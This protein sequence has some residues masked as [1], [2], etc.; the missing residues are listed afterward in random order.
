LRDHA[1]AISGDQVWHP[2]W[3]L[4]AL[5]ELLPGPPEVYPPWPVFGL[6]DLSVS[7]LKRRA[8]EYLI[9]VLN[10]F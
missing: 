7:L 6:C 1:I 5:I 2:Y 9:S 3:D 4:I 8:D 10:S